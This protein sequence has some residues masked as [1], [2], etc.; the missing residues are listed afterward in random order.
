[1][2]NQEL[3]YDLRATVSGGLGSFLARSNHHILAVDRVYYVG[4]P[5]AVVVATDRYLAR[6]AA[7]LVEI[8]Y[9]VRPAVA[10][11]EKAL[12]PG[13]PKVHPQWE[14]NVAFNY[15]QESGDVDKVFGEAEVIV[16]QRITSQRLIPTSMETRGVVAESAELVAHLQARVAAAAAGQP[17][18]AYA[19]LV[20][21]IR[22]YL[23]TDAD[24][25]VLA[26]TSFA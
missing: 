16:T 21:D 26:A 12:A 15:H 14:D 20:P 13:A 1:M 11:P 10:D 4:H 23:A 17:T 9:D 7:D 5:V 24:R 25:A 8:D 18:E 22:A 2:R 3:G 6:D 19:S